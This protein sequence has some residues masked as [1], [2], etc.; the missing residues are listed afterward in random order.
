[1]KIVH[2]TENKDGT[3]HVVVTEKVSRRTLLGLGRREDTTVG[4]AEYL[5]A[6]IQITALEPTS[7]DPVF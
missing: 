4:V 5:R 3:F 1:M 6:V 7:E 2:A